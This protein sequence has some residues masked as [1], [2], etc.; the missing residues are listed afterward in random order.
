MKFPVT[1]TSE[2]M[3]TL[4]IGRDKQ[5]DGETSNDTCLQS[6]SKIN[7]L[8]GEAWKERQTVALQ[9]RTK[10]HAVSRRIPTR[11]PSF[12]PRSGHVGSVV[13]KVAL[14]HVFSE[15]FCFRCQFSFCRLLHIN[16]HLASRAGAI[17]Q[18]VAYVPSGLS[19]TSF[20][21]RKKKNIG[22][23]TT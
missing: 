4:L 17:G 22:T 23:V 14:G 6:F 2:I 11:W 9:S 16:H 13:D 21:E 1:H 18:L 19:L 10:A 20:K 3:F 5:G 12:E 8:N 7:Q 15:Y